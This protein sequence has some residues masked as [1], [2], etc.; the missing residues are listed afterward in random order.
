MSRFENQDLTNDNSTFVGFDQRVRSW[1]SFFVSLPDTQIF[2]HLSNGFEDCSNS[3]W[4]EGYKAKHQNRNAM[5]PN[6]LKAWYQ[7][8]SSDD[9]A[10]W[11]EN[12]IMH[13]DRKPK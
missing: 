2:Y 13:W 12:W 1:P 6:S 3:C 7:A 11:E 8:I 10:T 4:L 9:G 5:F